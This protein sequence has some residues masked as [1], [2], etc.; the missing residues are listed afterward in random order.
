ME[1]TDPDLSA[2]RIIAEHR[3]GVLRDIAS[4]VARHDANVVMVH[5]E[6][7]DSGPHCG[8]AELY[9]ESRMERPGSPDP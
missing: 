1:R 2:I 5:Q 8:L 9:V 7:F 3:K 4:V 6:I